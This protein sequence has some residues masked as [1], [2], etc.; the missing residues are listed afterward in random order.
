MVV[1]LLVLALGG[2]YFLYDAARTACLAWETDDVALWLIACL[3]LGFSL[4]C[5]GLF[6]V[7]L[8]GQL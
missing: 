5:G 2:C 1:T 7:R 3:P 6:W 8:G 4:M